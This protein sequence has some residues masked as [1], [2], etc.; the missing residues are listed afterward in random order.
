MIRWLKQTAVVATSITAIGGFVGYVLS[1]L[2]GLDDGVLRAFFIGH[3]T[4]LVL[5]LIFLVI[6]V[7]SYLAM[8]HATEQ[9]AASLNNKID[10][11]SKHVLEGQIANFYHRHITDGRPCTDLDIREYHALEARRVAIGFNSFNEARMRQIQQAIQEQ[12]NA[13]L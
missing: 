5:A 11:I 2:L 13:V 1:N 7:S 10:L 6:S 4:E 8:Q 9:I 3:K 12:Q